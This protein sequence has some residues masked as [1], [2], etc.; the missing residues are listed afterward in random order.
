VKK[1]IFVLIISMLPLTHA[2][3]DSKTIGNV[4]APRGVVVVF[5]TSTDGEKGVVLSVS[6]L[7]SI[8]RV[9]IELS[10]Q[11]LDKLSNLLEA[12]KV[13]YNKENR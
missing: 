6:D 7:S 9:F 13:E 3:A 2:L 1:F 5:V 8:N 12:A 4:M 10:P 11:N